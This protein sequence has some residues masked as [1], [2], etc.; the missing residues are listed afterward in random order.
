MYF[1]TT[2]C[3][4][5]VFISTIACEDYCQTFAGGSVYPHTAN[6]LETKHQLQY[7]KAVS[8]FHNFINYLTSMSNVFDLIR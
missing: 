4:Q 8:K 2:L 6:S 1:V 7:T 5:L 3:L